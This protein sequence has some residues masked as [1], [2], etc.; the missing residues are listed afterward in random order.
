VQGHLGFVRLHAE[1]GLDE[2]G[3]RTN[4]LASDRQRAIA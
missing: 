2:R 3:M 1:R 4:S